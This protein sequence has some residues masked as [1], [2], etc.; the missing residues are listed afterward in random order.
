MKSGF[1]IIIIAFLF[2]SIKCFS[3]NFSSGFNFN[4]PAQ[5]TSS[6]KFLPKFYSSPINDENF[7]EINSN[8]N[9][10]VNG[11]AIRFWGTNL[12]AGGAFPEK[13]KAWFIA[14]RLRKIGFNL[15]RFHHMDNPWSNESLFEYGSDTRH[16]N[17]V[18]L[19][20]FEKLISELKKN[21]VY[22]DVNLHVSRTFKRAEWSG[23]C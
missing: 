18:T 19:D 4:L 14:G 9:F 3:Q 16:L 20:K 6:S 11:N 7:I 12:V 10:S 23:R 17:Q 8:G 2:T 22:A 13:T 15:V 1:Y 5:D 21:G